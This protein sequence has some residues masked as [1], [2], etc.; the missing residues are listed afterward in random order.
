MTNSSQN[1]SKKPKNLSAFFICLIIAAIIWLIHALN[2]VYI[3]S[4]DINVVFKNVPEN[5]N[6]EDL[7]QRL[8][9]GVKG[10]GLKLLLANWRLSEKVIELNMNDGLSK[11]KS[12][13]LLSNNTEN[14]LKHFDVNFEIRYVSPDT[15]YINSALDNRKW[16]GLILPDEFE[17]PSKWQLGDVKIS[18]EKIEVTGDE[19]LLRNI[20]EV[21]V[22]SLIDTGYSVSTAYY[23]IDLPKGLSSLTHFVKIESVNAYDNIKEIEVPLFINDG[24]VKYNAFPSSIRIKYS[25]DGI[26]LND[27][28][29]R[30]QLEIES[31]I[32][33]D[34]K[35]AV[36][37]VFSKN[38]SIRIISFSPEKVDLVKLKK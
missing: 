27:E 15:I 19:N 24:V 12:I 16:V 32:S 22:G 26:T 30:M 2:T 13:M 7:P 10:T 14:I 17:L 33:E 1:N 28:V 21:Y 29:L 3:K 18:P 34:N 8:E 11:N 5:V 25:L 9:I 23:K 20:N 38:K 6:V 37:D 31:D 35:Q 4:F 36:L